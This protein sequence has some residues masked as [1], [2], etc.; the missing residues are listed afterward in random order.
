MVQVCSKCSI[1]K[2]LDEFYW[3]NDQASY[4]RDCKACVCQGVRLNAQK[5]YAEDP[6]YWRK[7]HR[8][9]TEAKPELYRRIS[10]CSARRRRRLNPLPAL[11]AERMYRTRFPERV[12]NAQRKWAGENPDWFRIKDQRRKAFAAEL[13][14]TLT[15]IEWKEIQVE[16]GHKCAYCGSSRPLEQDHVIPLS[17]GGPY[18]KS[19]IV[20]ACKPCN[21]SKRDQTPDEWVG[22]LT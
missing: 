9:K 18:T 17:R 15:P 19:N 6:D 7:S 11:E 20:P 21:A 3:R 4:R 13:P 8:R 12:R 2:A 16:H 14:A 5:R 1:E 10:R 22:R